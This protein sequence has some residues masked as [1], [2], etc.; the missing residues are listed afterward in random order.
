MLCTVNEWFLFIC[1]QILDL[2]IPKNSFLHF[3]LIHGFMVVV[4]LNMSH[5]KVL[6]I[7]RK[8]L[9]LYPD[10]GDTL[11]NPWEYLH[12]NI[13]YCYWP[14]STWR[15]K[16][17]PQKP[18]NTFIIWTSSET[19]SQLNSPRVEYTRHLVLE[20]KENASSVAI[21]VIYLETALNGGKF[22]L[23]HP[24]GSLLWA[25]FALVSLFGILATHFILEA[26]SLP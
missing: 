12:N 20:V 7:N 5:L 22:W 13:F 10:S 24:G 6:W 25:L 18:S 21:E 2:M 9:L 1:L 11:E 3:L 23:S 8:Y 4:E 16:M 17:V 14:N 19:I 26:L 15:Q